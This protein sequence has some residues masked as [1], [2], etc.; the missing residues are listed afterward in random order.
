MKNYKRR[1]RTAKEPSMKIYVRNNDINGA[2]RI[3][4]KK[5]MK[6]GLFQELRERTSYSTRGEKRR[7]AK[8]AGIRRFQRKMDKRKQELGY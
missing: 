7:R 3:L 1:E 8:A 2:I 4:K 6:E 5:L